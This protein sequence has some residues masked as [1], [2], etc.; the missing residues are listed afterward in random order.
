MHGLR[1]K[2]L[3]IHAL[4]GESSR[5]IRYDVR[6]IAQVTCHARSGRY[7]M[8][9]REANHHH[10]INPFFIQLLLQVSTDEGT[11][12]MPYQHRLTRQ[13]RYFIPERKT[14]TIRP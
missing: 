11:V 14:G 4:F 3:T 9:C 13:R 6:V 12:H 8:F 10:R 7:T 5:S 2:T 1:I